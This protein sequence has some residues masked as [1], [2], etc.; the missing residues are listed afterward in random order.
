MRRPCF[1][2]E[3]S[4]CTGQERPGF[5]VFSTPSFT[6]RRTR[7][8]EQEEQRDELLEKIEDLIS[9]KRYAELRDLLLP[10]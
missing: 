3:I 7:M 1:H 10:L 9:R 2:K 5:F 6:E 4:D 8:F